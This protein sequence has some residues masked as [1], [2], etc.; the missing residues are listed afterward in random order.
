M[1]SAGNGQPQNCVRN[2]LSITKGEVPYERAMGIDGD[3]FDKPT[4]EVKDIVL[5]DAQ[6]Q[7]EKYEPRV[8]INSIETIVTEDGKHLSIKP[9]ITVTE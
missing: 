5:V 6:E 3:L 8:D 9:D 1:R 4:P 7:I 2:I